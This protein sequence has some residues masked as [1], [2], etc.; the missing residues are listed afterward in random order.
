MDK[1]NSSGIADQ[2][3]FDIRTHRHLGTV[4]IHAADAWTMTAV[5]AEAFLAAS[6]ARLDFGRSSSQITIGDEQWVIGFVRG[7]PMRVERI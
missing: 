5:E 1:V 3:C 4:E 6:H 2:S 7:A